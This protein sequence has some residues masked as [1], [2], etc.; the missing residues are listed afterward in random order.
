MVRVSGG[1]ATGFFVLVLLAGA[2][3]SAQTPKKTT[4]TKSTIAEPAVYSLEQLYRAADSVALVKILSGDTEHYQVAVYKG[5]VVEA[6]TGA[7]EKQILYF[8]PFIGSRLGSVY[9][10]FLR[11]SNRQLLP[12]HEGELSYGTV[13]YFTVFNEG[14]SS[15]EISYQ[16]IF[17]GNGPTDKCDYGVRVCT[18]YIKLPKSLPVFPPMSE[19]TAFGCRWVRRDG[20][21]TYLRS[22]GK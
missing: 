13:P 12:Q 21:L 2:V 19:D 8:G 3:S 16:C 7:S 1:A 15:M 6:F 5:E 9:L 10:L 4:T 11:K 22:L 20:F 17:N 14:Y 18:D